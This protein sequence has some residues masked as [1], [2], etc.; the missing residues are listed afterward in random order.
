MS[1]FKKIQEHFAFTKNEQKVFFFLAVVM[2]IGAGIKFVRNY[3]AED[4]NQ[5]F[6]YSQTDSIFTERSK[7]IEQLSDTSDAK[8]VSLPG[9]GESMAERI[10]LYRQ[11]NGKFKTITDLKKI[12]GIGDK[13]FERLKEFIE[14]R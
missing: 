5:H 3:T 10:L 6:D 11:D 4:I 7:R 9:I 12:K 2:L 14:I 1:I 8:P 13:K